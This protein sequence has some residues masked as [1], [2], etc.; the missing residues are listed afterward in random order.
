MNGESWLTYM[1]L[2]AKSNISMYYAFLMYIP[3]FL[4]ELTPEPHFNFAISWESVVSTGQNNK[5]HVCRGFITWCNHG[6]SGTK[7]G[8]LNDQQQS[9]TNSFWKETFN[10]RCLFRQPIDLQYH[11]YC[12]RIDWWPRSI[13][14]SRQQ[15][16]PSKAFQRDWQPS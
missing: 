11:N 15:P 2:R 8:V 5:L 12:Y 1:L 4:W 3:S 14:W 9:W 16:T 10:V 6:S 13:E 7:N